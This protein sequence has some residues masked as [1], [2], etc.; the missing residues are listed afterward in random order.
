ML[1]WGIIHILNLTLLVFCLLD[2]FKNVILPEW[3]LL[4]EFVG[5]TE[6]IDW[7]LEMASYQ[8]NRVSSDFVYDAAISK[9]CFTADKDAVNVWHMN[10]HC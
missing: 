3:E 1:R 10:G 8:G 4:H 7:F 9:Y 2:H 6:Y 5:F